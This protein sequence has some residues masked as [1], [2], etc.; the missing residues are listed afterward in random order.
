MDLYSKDGSL[1]WSTRVTEGPLETNCILT[2]QAKS[3]TGL[4]F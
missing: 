1:L 4:V 2:V 3:E